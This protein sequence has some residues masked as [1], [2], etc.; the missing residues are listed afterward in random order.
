MQLPLPR[1]LSEVH[2]RRRRNR[3]YS[4]EMIGAI[5]PTPMSAATVDS[6]GSMKQRVE[7]L[8]ASMA[9]HSL[10]LQGVQ[11]D[12]KKLD[13]GFQGQQTLLAS[14]NQ[15]LTQLHAASQQVQRQG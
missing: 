5:V 6:S 1:S 11:Q 7:K 14:M 15:M 13:A 3:H 10:T 12:V 8:E 9:S 4:K 2:R